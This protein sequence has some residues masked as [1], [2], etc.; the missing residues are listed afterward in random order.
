MLL[1]EVENIL[2][3]CP[4][5]CKSGQCKNSDSLIDYQD[6]YT[7]S[8]SEGNSTDFE[9]LSCSDQSSKKL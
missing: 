1:D 2:D 7:N 3:N 8:S 6:Y 5:V 4:E 9:C